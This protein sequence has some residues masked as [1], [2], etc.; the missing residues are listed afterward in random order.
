MRVAAIDCGTNSI[1]LLIADAISMDA[2][3]TSATYLNDVVREMR[4]VRLGEGVDETHAFSDEALARTFDAADEYADIIRRHGAEGIRFVATSATRDA[5]NS[6]LLKRGIHSRLGVE[7]DV[8]SGEEE[9]QL[10]FAGALSA[11][12]VAEDDTVLV[13]DLGGGSTEF[14]IGTRSGVERAISV[15][16]GCV[17]FTERYLTTDPP[18][19]DDVTAARAEIRA[20][21]KSVAEVIPFEKV[22]KVIGVAGSVTTITAHGLML[23]HYES[24]RINGAE[25]TVER[26]AAAT[27]SLLTMTRE[28]RAELGFMHP[29][30][31]D[32]IGAGA[33]IWQEILMRVREDSHGR[34]THASASE[35]DI[36]D[37]IALSLASRV[38][39]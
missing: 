16:M 24:E 2:D 20:M 26:Y 25:L 6:E 18:R 38:T 7:P 23:D 39:L 36:L 14:V 11:V 12:D 28:K 8:I 3:R 35:H 21:L 5:T 30:R 1:R 9:A 13:V 17:R 19:L 31:V 10:S 27:Q 4:I 22:T 15:N 37:G 29:G 33:L 34:V 32:V